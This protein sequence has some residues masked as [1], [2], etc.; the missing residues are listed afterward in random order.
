MMILRII[1]ASG[2]DL[3]KKERYTDSEGSG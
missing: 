1:V 2:H 3:I